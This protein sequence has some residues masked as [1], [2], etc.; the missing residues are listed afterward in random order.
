MQSRLDN[1]ALQCHLLTV[2]TSTVAGIV[3]AIEEYLAVRVPDRLIV[4]RLERG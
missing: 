4:K 3:R 1:R 2:D